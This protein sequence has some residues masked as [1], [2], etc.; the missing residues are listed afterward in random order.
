MDW[1]IQIVVAMQSWGPGWKPVM[2]GLTFLGRIEFFLFLMAILYW[3]FSESLGL[4]LGFLLV[5]SHAVGMVSKLLFH[6]PRPYW[7]DLRVAAL[8]AESTYA[9][10]SQ[11]ALTAA[12]IWPWIGKRLGGFFGL[13]AGVAIAIAIGIARIY[14]GVHSP[15]DVIA[16]WLIGAGVCW[17]VLWGARVFGPRLG[18]AGLWWQIGISSAASFLLLAIQSVILWAM[19]PI[20]DPPPWAIWAARNGA[21]NPRDPNAVVAIAGIL[22]G[23]GI[24]LACQRRWA[25]FRADGGIRNKGLRLLIGGA[26]LVSFSA[27]A[28]IIPSTESNI[29]ALVW[30]YIF[31]ALT[32]YWLVFLAP[33]LFLRLR[34]AE[35]ALEAA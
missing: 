5:L 23:G 35:R 4:R 17:L 13:L 2:D 30:H 20:I 1:G 32:A 25:R 19:A 7:V 34:F 31:S 18:A 15:A 11:H 8:S 9:M 33:W 21:I 12:A 28:L 10:P 6:L 24:G 27:L 14:L 29:T 16:G 22:L 3:C 26:G